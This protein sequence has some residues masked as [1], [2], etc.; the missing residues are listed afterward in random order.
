MKAELT[1]TG[2]IVKY[3]DQYAKMGQFVD[4]FRILDDLAEL[5]KQRDRVCRKY[6][7]LYGTTVSD[8]VSN[9]LDDFI[10]ALPGDVR[11]G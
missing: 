8:A 4:I 11:D 2:I 10:G 3:A 9:A 6:Q 7:R 1:L 5:A